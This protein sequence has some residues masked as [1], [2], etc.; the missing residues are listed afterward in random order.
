MTFE[1]WMRNQAPVQ[2]DAA[3]LD[4]QKHASQGLLWPG[5]RAWWNDAYNIQDEPA[6]ANPSPKTF[7]DSID[8][9]AARVYSKAFAPDGKLYIY[10][11]GITATK[12]PATYTS[13]TRVQISPNPV[14]LGED[15]RIDDA[16]PN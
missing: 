4:Y 6:P 15:G 12:F 5:I 11:P 9:I 7:Q 13:L 14:V 2:E 3:N 8:S 16:I 1:E 10:E